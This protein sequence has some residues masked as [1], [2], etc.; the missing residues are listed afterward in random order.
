VQL[1]KPSLVR[2]W[3]SEIPLIGWGKSRAVAD[4]F[5]SALHMASATEKQWMKIDGIGRTIAQG[6]VE[7][8]RKENQVI[9]EEGEV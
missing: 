2:R 8:I 5:P 6:A 4:F 3:A 7:A 9:K 1:V